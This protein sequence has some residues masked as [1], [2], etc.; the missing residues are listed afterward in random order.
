MSC[1]IPSH[2]DHLNT[3]TTAS[4]I[5]TT[6]FFAGGPVSK[7]SGGVKSSPQQHIPSHKVHPH[8]QQSQHQAKGGNGAPPAAT[9]V[10]MLPNHPSSG[11]SNG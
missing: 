7:S 3:A 4:K 10:S 5:N 1:K 6:S 2:S 11:S 9:T 8:Q